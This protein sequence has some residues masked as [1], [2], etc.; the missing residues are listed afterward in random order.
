MFYVQIG[1]MVG[2]NA[3]FGQFIWHNLVPVALG[4]LIGGAFFLGF[5]QWLAY[6]RAALKRFSSKGIA[7]TSDRIE[8]LINEVP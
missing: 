4:N 1:L 3:T 5:A 6:D 8:P 2:A 7:A